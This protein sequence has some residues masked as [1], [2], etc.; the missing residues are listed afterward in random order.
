VAGAVAGWPDATIFAD[1]IDKTVFGGR[2]PATPPF[3]E[4]FQQI[5]SRF[6]QHLEGLG[7]PAYGMLVQ[8]RNDT[9]SDRLTVMMRAFHRRG[10]RWRRN[11]NLLVETPLFVDSRLTS[12]VQVSDVCAYALRRYLENGEDEL[13]NI[14]FPKFAMAG[15]RC[16][17]ARHYRGVRPC[18]CRV[19]A[20]H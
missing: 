17:G 16:V 20:A 2:M 3:E 6:H 7:G 8:D 11:I 18:A 5:V 19:C 13:F 12:M 15:A 4:A 10:T 9:V 1:C 14:V